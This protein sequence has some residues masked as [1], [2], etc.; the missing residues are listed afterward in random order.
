[1]VENQGIY[2]AQGHFPTIFKSDQS[3]LRPGDPI[4][5]TFEF[6]KYQK[7][8]L[9]SERFQVRRNKVEKLGSPVKPDYFKFIINF[10]S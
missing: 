7:L 3:E 2:A 5:S 1:M 8:H 9:K 6:A 10:R 4:F